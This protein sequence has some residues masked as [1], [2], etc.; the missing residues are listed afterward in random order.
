MMGRMPADRQDGSA[1][2]PELRRPGLDWT[3]ML[4]RSPLEAVPECVAGRW[5]AAHTRPRCEKLLAEDL[6]V[7]GVF[8]YL[9]VCARTTR[10]RRTG[11][12]SR[13][14][15]PVFTG[16]VF[17]IAD[18]EQRIR[19]LA[20]NRIVTLLPVAAQD[21]LIRQ[22]RSV[23]A[24]VRHGLDVECGPAVHVGDWVRVVA[25]P[26]AGL[27]GRVLQRRSSMRLIINVR[28][29]AQSV[30]VDISRDTVEPLAGPP[31]QAD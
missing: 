16:Y 4:R 31:D 15:V 1:A 19:A 29:L 13:S 25:G 3:A 5:W 10:S 21:E 8:Q 7:R 14:I 26:L 27:A 30:S 24:V 6:A 9:P 23:Q 2:A 20:T 18:E 17:F 28:I 12:R 11:R 22:L